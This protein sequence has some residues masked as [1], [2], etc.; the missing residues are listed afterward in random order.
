MD[1]LL[2]TVL[3]HGAEAGKLVGAGGGG[4][5]LLYLE[6]ERRQAVA[7]AAAALHGAS[8]IPFEFV[9]YGTTITRVNP[10]STEVLL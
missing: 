4:F 7:R 9:P 3:R 6:P 1:D 8:E 2:R 10:S 5:L